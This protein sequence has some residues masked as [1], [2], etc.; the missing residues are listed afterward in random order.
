MPK[1]NVLLLTADDMN[2]NFTGLFGCEVPDVAPNINALAAQGLTFENAHVTI[3]VCQPSR[4]VLLTGRYPHR[5]G[6]RGF[7]QIDERVTTL[8]EVL[9][10]AG[11]Y[12]GIIGK[13]DHLAPKEKFA[14]DEYVST[15]NDENDF[16]RSPASYY[17]HTM[18]F[19]QNARQSGAPF[20]LMANSHDPHRPFANSDEE[21][22]FFG[23]HIAVNH[24]YAPEEIEV[25]G[26]LPDIPKVR[27]E[28]A[29]YYSS[30]RRCDECVGEVLQ[31]LDDAGFAEDTLVLFLSDNGMA[32]PFAKTNCYL[33]S[34]KSPWVL[35]W[36]GHTKPGAKTGALVSGIDFTPTV[37][38]AIGLAPLQGVDGTTLLPVLEDAAREHYETIYTQ[39]FKTARNQ[40]TKAERHYPMRC[41]QNKQFAYIYNAWS[42]GKA[43]FINESMS[44]MTFNAMEEAAE[45]SEEIAARVRLCQYRVKEELFDYVNDP[46]ALCNLINEPD[47]REMAGDFRKKMQAYMRSTG[48]ELLSAFLKDIE[49][50]EATTQ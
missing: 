12:N 31:A 47:Y 32:F 49:T 24:Q 23:R 13:E 4:S 50:E 3:A 22:D 21:I 2:Y 35:R 19:L 15:Y 28:I 40:I 41:V 16:G 25:P 9:R 37:L 38:D 11:Y 14:W 43:V 29:Q 34:T 17:R 5:N 30:V 8:T 42:D 7:E 6:A 46:D 44:G 39:F 1:T 26:F 18:N 48:D 36:P 27:Q 33:N 10:Q 45:T 20:F